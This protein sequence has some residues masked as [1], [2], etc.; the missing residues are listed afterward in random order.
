MEISLETLC[1]LALVAVGSLAGLYGWS[2]I[3]IRQLEQASKELE[4]SQSQVYRAH[5]L[6]KEQLDDLVERVEAHRRDHTALRRGV[7]QREDEEY[8]AAAAAPQ[9]PI[10]A[11][12]P[13]ERTRRI[14]L[15]APPWL[16]RNNLETALA[17]P[18]H[19]TFEVT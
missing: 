8:E 9:P 6:L 19:L 12:G 4:E 14:V 15:D 16:E 3:Q 5:A 7:W 11:P 2:F 13:A 1:S 17:Q 10:A 18:T